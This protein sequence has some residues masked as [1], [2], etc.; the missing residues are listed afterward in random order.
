MSEKIL[1]EDLINYAKKFIGRPYKYGAKQY[2]IPKVFDCSAFIQYIY[3]KI[4]VKLPRTALRQAHF[5]KTISINELRPGDLIFAK[6]ITGRYNVE[7]PKGVG[8]V[9]MFIGDNKVIQ[10]KYRKN[11][12][13]SNGGMVEISDVKK[14]LSKKDLTIIKRIIK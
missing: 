2:E 3:K 10:A 11:E 1:I 4:G 13:G 6:G 14:L 8:H 5:G 9:A 12:D 7:F